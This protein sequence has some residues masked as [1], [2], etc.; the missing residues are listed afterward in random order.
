MGRLLQA[1]DSD[2]VR[3]GKDGT[4]TYGGTLDEEWAIGT[5]VH[6]GVSL[7][8]VMNAVCQFMRLPEQESNGIK[9][10]D[11]QHIAGSMLAAAAI[12]TP[13]E[14]DITLIKKGRGFSTLEAKLTQPVSLA[15]LPCDSLPP[16]LTSS[17]L[18]A[19]R[20]RASRKCASTPW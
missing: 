11:P 4:A 20:T 6:G 18:C 16:E 7:S 17:L 12:G 3:D 10:H 9:H 15:F 13:F 8:L 1:I 14:I 19:P 2:L 5:V